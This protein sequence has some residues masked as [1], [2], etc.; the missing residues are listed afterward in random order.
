MLDVLEHLFNPVDT[1]RHALVLLT[2]KG[3]I[4]VTVPAFNVLWTNHDVINHHLRRYTKESLR[5]VAEKAGMLIEEERYWFQWTFPAKLAQRAVEQL[6]RSNPANPG[7]PPPP[8]N[9]AF[10]LLSRAELALAGKVPFP[11]GSSLFVLGRKA[12]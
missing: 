12:G 7:I 2:G 10:Y 1:I 11:F 4:L 6:L 9:R 8:I 5:A 3:T